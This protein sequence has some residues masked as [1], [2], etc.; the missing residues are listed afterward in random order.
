MRKR[1]TKDATL[2]LS[3]DLADWD[4][5]EAQ[6]RIL[7]RALHLNEII[8]EIRAVLVKPRELGHFRSETEAVRRRP[9]TT[10]M[11]EVR[12]EDEPLAA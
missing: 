11:V 1:A 2:N 3:S 8:G 10:R 4:I 6:A 7:L 9:R 12:E 5:G